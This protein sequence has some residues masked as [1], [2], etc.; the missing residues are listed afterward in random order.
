M[1]LVVELNKQEIQDVHAVLLILYDMEE[2]LGKD[3]DRQNAI[4]LLETLLAIVV[5]RY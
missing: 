2:K 4:D 3:D 5:R 1:K